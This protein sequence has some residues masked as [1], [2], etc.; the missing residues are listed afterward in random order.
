[1]LLFAIFS[2][3]IG[4]AVFAERV[5]NLKTP[6]DISTA[7]AI[8]VLTGGQSRLEPAID[9]LANK[10]AKRLLISG[11]H[12]ATSKSA[13]SNAVGLHKTLFECCVDLGYKAKDTVGN[14]S[15]AVEWLQ[16]N[17]FKSL[18]LVTNNYHM[19]RSVLEMHRIGPTIT[20]RP[21]PVVNND[22]TNGRWM[23]KQETVRV[24]LSEY[25]KYI[26]ATLRIYLPIPNSLASLLKQ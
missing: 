24:L 19:P 1:M 4:F 9:L 23:L 18:I 10:K 5:A 2:F 13:L 15:E 14:A 11:A 3:L 7:D 22:L 12:P 25:I 6:D 17:D 20:V 8:V 21:Y 16:R 26:G